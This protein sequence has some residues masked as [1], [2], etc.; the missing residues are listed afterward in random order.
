MFDFPP[1]MGNLNDPNVHFHPYSPPCDLNILPS[2]G[3]WLVDLVVPSAFAKKKMWM[4]MWYFTATQSNLVGGF[5]PSEKYE[6]KWVSSP[7]RGQNKKCLK[8]PPRNHLEVKNRWVIES[9]WQLSVTRSYCFC[10]KA[11]LRFSL[12]R[13][14]QLPI[15]KSWTSINHEMSLRHGIILFVRVLCTESVQMNLPSQHTNEPANDTEIFLDGGCNPSDFFFRQFGSSSPSFGV[16]IS[17][18]LWVATT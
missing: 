1:N 2:K 3:R 17:K 16:K 11:T 10:M 7:G 9:I 12:R 15:L 14:E 6:S 5:N 18:N 13:T 8:P 4:N